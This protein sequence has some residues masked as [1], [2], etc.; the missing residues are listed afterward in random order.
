MT[1]SGADNDDPGG[2]A[3]AIAFDRVD[4]VVPVYNEA[5]TVPALLDRLRAAC[6]G[7]ALIFVDNGS[8]DATCELLEAAADVTLVRHAS[9]LGYGRSL[10]D[11]IAAGRRPF[12]VQIDA[13]LEYRPEDVP[14]VVAE[15]ARFEAVY[16]SR[17][18]GRPGPMAGMSATRRLGN[19]VVTGLFDLLYGQ[20]LSDLYTGLRA[21]RRDA[22][23]A[24]C[25]CEG[26]EY[27]FEVAAR[28]VRGGGRIGEVAIGYDARETGASKM[29]HVPEFLKFAYWL[30]RLR[31][32][33]AP[34]GTLRG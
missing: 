11:G 23:T 26:F 9:N 12:V 20:D 18:L 6:P 27:V 5:A 17:F 29:R 30:V 24:P 8:T 13:D 33:R 19:R 22:L 25:R 10:R 3:D 34:R 7:A 2:A 28:L 16:G 31:L 14:A 21:F 4:V 1:V 32:E 15:L